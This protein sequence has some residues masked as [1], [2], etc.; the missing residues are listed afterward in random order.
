[1][2]NNFNVWLIDL[3]LLGEFLEC[4]IIVL[5]IVVDIE[6][7]PKIRQVLAINNSPS[8]IHQY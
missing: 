6:I 2:I 8:E 7:A 5:S 4:F 3:H 1:M